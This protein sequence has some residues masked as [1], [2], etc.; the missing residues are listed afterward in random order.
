LL[1]LAL[2]V[3]IS[4]GSTAL[5]DPPIAPPTDPSDV[6]TVTSTDPTSTVAAV[7]LPPSLQLAALHEVKEKTAAYRQDVWH[8]QTLMGLHR[9]GFSRAAARTH[10]LPYANWILKVW[11][12]RARTLHIRAKRWMAQRMLSLRVS[13]KQWRSAMGAKSPR[14][15]LSAS[16]SLE[17]RFNQWRRL[18][19]QTHAQ[20]R[21]P[22]QKANFLCI[23]RF[24]GSWTDRDSGHN[25]HYGGV[26][27]GK[28]EW[29]KFGRPYT[30]KEYPYQASMLDQ[31]W[32]AYRYWL[33]S[34]FSPWSQT[35][36]NCGL[37]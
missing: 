32:A 18:A 1:V 9:T 34:G 35:A 19:R 11:K 20:Y 2:I 31:L 8:W 28:D 22:P 33:V 36:P 25:G 3:A 14:R 15:E 13:V 7:T 6:P 10:S 30:H 16:G 27:M 29:D 12:T 21:N 26:Q 24:E 5:G 23:H 37:L 4:A 17:F